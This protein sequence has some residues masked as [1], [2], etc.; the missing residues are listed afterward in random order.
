MSWAKLVSQPP[1]E[2]ALRQ[3]ALNEAARIQRA[4]EARAQTLCNAIEAC[5]GQVGGWSANY[6]NDALHSVE[7]TWTG[8]EVALAETLW[9]AKYYP[10]LRALNVESL[11]PILK[12]SGP[13]TGKV[14]ADFIRDKGPGKVGRH[15]IHVV[16]K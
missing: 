15:I 14:V 1:S 3:A 16:L 8:P 13:H 2:E 11:P 12:H 9:L 6:P 5:T 7:G 4:K 10:N